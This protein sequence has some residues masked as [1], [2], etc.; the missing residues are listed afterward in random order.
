MNPL[1]VISLPLSCFSNGFGAYQNNYHSLL[2]VYFTLA[3]LPLHERRRLLCN[4]LITLGPFASSFCNAIQSL[5]PIHLELE[6][7]LEISLYIGQDLMATTLVSAF[8]LVHCSNS[9]Q[10]NNSSG[11]LRHNATFGCCECLIGKDA[12]QDLDYDIYNDGR[13][14]GIID[15]VRAKASWLNTKTQRQKT[16]SEFGLAEEKSVWNTLAPALPQFTAYAYK[17]CYA[18][19]SGIT[20]RVYKLINNW[21]LTEVCGREAYLIAFRHI[22]L[23]AGWQQFQNPISHI[24]LYGFAEKGCLSL[25]QPFIFS[26]FLQDVYIR[27]EALMGIK[28]EFATKLT[29]TTASGTT[30]SK[31]FLKLLVMLANSNPMVLKSPLSSNDQKEVCNKLIDFRVYF[32]RF[33][34]LTATSK[35]KDAG[36]KAVRWPNIHQALHAY[37]CLCDFASLRN[38]EVSVR[39][40]KHKQLKDK[41]QRTNKVHFDKQLILDT[42]QKEA[43]KAVINQAEAGKGLWICMHDLTSK[44]YGRIELDWI[45]LKYI[46][47]YMNIGVYGIGPRLSKW[48]SIR[49]NNQTP[50]V[51]QFTYIPAIYCI[52]CRIWK[53]QNNQ[54]KKRKKAPFGAPV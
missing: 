2:A 16:L 49:S 33:A 1:P 26:D 21:L 29:G 19:L 5:A 32:Q 51:S 20:T 8:F 4:K 46:Y 30:V 44:S 36:E 9:P 39:E 35:D 24:K 17:A 12:R 53:G 34:K 42:A 13:Y 25:I 18:D 14:Q 27:A 11:M 52:T 38:T 23:P 3:N 47:I 40:T 50:A 48:P 37:Q 43:I 41:A 7:G 45:S 15:A 22:T 31:L 6:K 10:Q 28:K 54:R